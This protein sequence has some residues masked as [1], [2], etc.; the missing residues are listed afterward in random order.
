MAEDQ[1][2]TRL[3]RVETNP[4][5]AHEG[6]ATKLMFSRNGLLSQLP[7]ER[8]GQV[9]VSSVGRRRLKRDECGSPHEGLTA[10]VAGGLL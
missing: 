4:G 9:A 7:H 3:F 2:T 1:E 8:G 6:G 5:A 10:F